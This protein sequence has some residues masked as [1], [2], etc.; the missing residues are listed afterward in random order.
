MFY[1]HDEP[2]FKKL[3]DDFILSS[4]HGDKSLSYAIKNIDLAA[5]EKGVSFYQ[6]MFILIQKT[7]LENRKKEW[8]N[9]DMP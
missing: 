7:S 8:L 4:I 2:G 5:A 9:K 3:I 1:H 6:M